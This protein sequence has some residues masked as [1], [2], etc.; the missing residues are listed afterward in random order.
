MVGGTRVVESCIG[1]LRDVD[2]KAG[3]YRPNGISRLAGG[4]F[5]IQLKTI[6]GTGRTYRSIPIID[7]ELDTRALLRVVTPRAE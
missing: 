7:L 1:M 4:P 5:V 2:A 6:R 3:Q